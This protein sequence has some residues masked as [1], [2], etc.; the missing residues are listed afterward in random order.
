MLHALS[1]ASARI[2]FER[3]P[4]H[5]KGEVKIWAFST[6][7]YA[8][9]DQLGPSES[10]SCV[11]QRDKPYFG[12]GGKRT[13]GMYILE[14]REDRFQVKCDEAGDKNGPKGSQKS[15]PLWLI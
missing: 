3:Q 9:I 6:F 8:F 12:G 5:G 11:L 4:S 1:I 10:V 13:E 14:S 7:Y 15:T 2:T